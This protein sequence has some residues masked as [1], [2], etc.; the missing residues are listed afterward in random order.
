MNF[1]KTGMTVTSDGTL[2]VLLNFG[3]QTCQIEKAREIHL[4]P[5]LW[6]Q[7]SNGRDASSNHCDRDQPPMLTGATPAAI[8]SHEDMQSQSSGPSVLTEP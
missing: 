3:T 6:Y 5:S 1:R 7:I 8:M 4:I 2:P